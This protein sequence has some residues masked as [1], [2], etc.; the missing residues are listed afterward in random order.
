MG[1][2]GDI[3]SSS[4]IWK[5]RLRLAS[6]INVRGGDHGQITVREVAGAL[7]WVKRPQKGR[8]GKKNAT[9]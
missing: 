6:W 7:G 2:V 5:N 9:R 8:A 4:E 1:V 3:G